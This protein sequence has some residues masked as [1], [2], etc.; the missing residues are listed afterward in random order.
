MHGFW[1]T[2]RSTCLLIYVFYIL[3]YYCC[4]GG[5]LWHLQKFLQY[6]IVEFTPSIILLYCPL[7]YSWNSF[8]RSH[9]SIYI[10]EYIFFTTV[11][12]LHPFLVSSPIL[13]VPSPKTGPVLPSCSP[14]FGKKKKK[15]HFCLFKITV[16]GVSLWHFHVYMFYYLNRF[17][18]L[19]F[20]FLL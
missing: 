13:L 9:F 11:S 15:R 16:R 5:T 1:K 6:I 10:Y 4:T 18:L 2:C 7:P 8:K 17:I 12:L 3:L 14:I 19:F 20:S